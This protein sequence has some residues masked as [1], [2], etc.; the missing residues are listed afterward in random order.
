[1]NN[2]KNHVLKVV[3]CSLLAALILCTGCDSFMERMAER[4]AERQEEQERS[5]DTDKDFMNYYRKEIRNTLL[6]RDKSALLDLFCETVV[7]N[8][9]DIDEGAEYIMDME[10]W[11]DI[12]VLR[13]N[14]SSYKEYA[15]GG[16]Y[17]FV[18]AWE[19]ISVGDKT[20][21]MYF[22]GYAKNYI[23]ERGVSKFSK[24]NTG[25]THLLIC[26][27]DEDNNPIETPYA[28]ICGIYHPGRL[29]YEILINTVL[30][31]YSSTNDD[32]SYID[33]MTDEALEA[34]MTPELLKSAD[35]DELEAFITFIRYGSQ[36]K[37]GDVY[38]FLGKQSGNYV[39]TATV[40][41]ELEDRALTLL[42]KDGLIDGAAFCD[43]TDPDMPGSGEVTGFYGVVD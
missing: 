31:T 28:G 23:E 18:N 14:S 34:I 27:L 15:S 5:F 13:S 36:S 26:E 16:H 38:V 21:R 7:E 43:G 24:E 40:H 39:L 41:F 10:E 20:Y 4:R 12:G 42:I 2:I 29:E 19:D 32:G 6:N 30:N 1:M 8:T 33:T 37:K 17:L 25:L 22:S 35:K 9:C 11:D 3:T